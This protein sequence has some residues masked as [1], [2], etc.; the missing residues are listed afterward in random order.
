MNNDKT[1]TADSIG[2]VRCISVD[3]RSA[4]SAFR[5]RLSFDTDTQKKMLRAVRGLNGHGV[6]I[7]TCC[8]TEL[9]HTC[10]D[11]KVL[12]LIGSYS[13]LRRDELLEHIRKYRGE[14]ALR[15]LFRVCGGLCSMVLGE[16]EILRQVKEAYALAAGEGAAGPV[17]N[18]CFQSAVACGKKIRTDTPISRLAVSYST[19]AANKAAAFCQGPGRVLVIG[20]G[21]EIGSSAVKNL[22][23]H[24]DITVVAALRSHGFDTLL[25][26]E[27]EREAYPE[28]IAAIAG[29]D[30]VISAT[31]SP[32]YT[33]TLSQLRKEGVRGRKLFIDLA[34][35]AD[36][37]EEIG[38]AEGFERL[39]ID[40]FRTLASDNLS[41]RLDS[42]QLAGQIV[43]E[44]LSQLEKELIY[45]DY[46]PME[47]SLAAALEK[48]PRKVLH[49]LKRDL[50]PEQLRAVLRTLSEV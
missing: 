29:A 34:V 24:K 23:S 47:Q 21:G 5:G 16:D 41:A 50:D 15:H 42:A 35:P 45:N 12:D 25:P 48:D 7:C 39:G 11:G 49:R 18:R 37:D 14:K 10:D 4:P 30:V 2:M 13:G 33:V 32:H 22:L 46:L 19:L 44:E 40:D 36:I 6:L 38:S 27:V 1:E 3:H 31:K 43:E 17:L 20:A 26:P 28:R 8:R 9:Y